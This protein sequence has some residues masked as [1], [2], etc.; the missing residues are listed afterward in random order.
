M[1]AVTGLYRLTPAR[2]AFTPEN[3]PAAHK[4]RLGRPGVLCN[5]TDLNFATRSDGLSVAQPDQ[6][7]DCRTSY[8]DGLPLGR[9]ELT[10]RARTSCRKGQHGGGC[11]PMRRV[12]VH[13]S[14][15]EADFMFAGQRR[16]GDHSGACQS[17][18][19]ENRKTVRQDPCR[20]GSRSPEPRGLSQ[21]PKASKR[22]ATGEHKERV[23]EICYQT[24]FLP[25][26]NRIASRRSCERAGAG[27]Q[28]GGSCSR[29]LLR[30]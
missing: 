22:K 10:R 29:R 23:A 8:D 12:G 14:V 15:M 9:L 30:G 13:G 17:E 20:T 19:V 6:R 18:V 3:I 4:E 1:A 7:Q 5:G 21:R 2:R 27:R 16:L 26:R 25:P 11:A 24:V 28:T